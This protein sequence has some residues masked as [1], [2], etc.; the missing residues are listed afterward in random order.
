MTAPHRPLQVWIAGLVVIVDQVTK[1]LLRSRLDLY[2]TITVIPGVLN[3]T[4]VHNTGAAFGLMNATDFP[5]KTIVLALVAAAALAAL[6]LYASTLDSAQWLS[7]LGLTF[8]IGGAAGNL[9]DRIA[10]GYV[11]DFVDVYWRGWHF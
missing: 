8:V 6:A 10:V 7:R 5:F 11:L 1:F 4:R 9:I 3:L 2:Q